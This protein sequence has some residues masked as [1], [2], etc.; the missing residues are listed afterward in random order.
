L[1]IGSGL[2]VEALWFRHLGV[3]V[4][5]RTALVAKLACFT[6]AF[7]AC[8]VVVAAV[9]LAAVR[10]TRTSGVVQVVLRRTGNGPTTLPELLAPVAGRLPWRRLALFV[11]VKGGVCWIGRYELLLGSY[12]AVFGAGYTVAHVKLPFQWILVAAALVGAGLAAAN[13][14]AQGWRLPVVAVVVVFGV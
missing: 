1:G 10:N 13:L 2:F 7:A 5:F 8:Y 11:L 14:R 12:G 4:V 3:F 6:L 9:G